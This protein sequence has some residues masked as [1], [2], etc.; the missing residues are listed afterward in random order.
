M[1]PKQ[2]QNPEGAA[3]NPAD[4]APNPAGAAPFANAAVNAAAAGNAPAN[5][6]PPAVAP[7]A[8]PCANNFFMIPPHLY[9]AHATPNHVCLCGHP[10]NAHANVAAAALAPAD[11]GPGQAVIDPQGLTGPSLLD[12]MPFCRPAGVPSPLISQDNPQ[13]STLALA[14]HYKASYAGGSPFLRGLWI[15]I[16][17]KSV[18]PLPLIFDRTVEMVPPRVGMTPDRVQLATVSFRF[19]AIP[20]GRTEYEVARWHHERGISL[21][22]H[23]GAKITGQAKR[24]EGSWRDIMVPQKEPMTAAEDVVARIVSVAMGLGTEVPISVILPSSPL[25]PGWHSCYWSGLL[26]ENRVD[27]FETGV[28]MI[29]LYLANRGRLG[30]RYM[31]R[32]AWEQRYGNGGGGTGGGRGGASQIAAAILQGLGQAGGGAAAAAGGAPIPPVAGPAAAAAGACWTCNQVGHIAANCPQGGGNR[33][34]RGRF[35]RRGGRGGGR[36]RGGGHY[37]GHGNGGHGGGGGYGPHGNGSVIPSVIPCVPVITLPACVPP[38]IACVHLPIA[39]EEDPVDDDDT[40]S[41]TLTDIMQDECDSRGE[42]RAEHLAGR[43]PVAPGPVFSGSGGESRL[44]HPAARGSGEPRPDDGG[45][46]GESN[47]EH[48]AV[49]GATAPGADTRPRPQPPRGSAVPDEDWSWVPLPRAETIAAGIGRM[50]QLPPINIGEALDRI[51]RHPRSTPAVLAAVGEARPYLDVEGKIHVRPLSNGCYLRLEAR[52]MTDLS[53]QGAIADL[54]SSRAARLV[55]DEQGRWYHRL[56]TVPK[57]DGGLRTISDLRS[58]NAVFPVP[59][60]FSHPS[61]LS[62]IL[63]GSRTSYAT[64]VDFRSAFYQ[65]RVSEDLARKF[66]FVFSASG[67]ERLAEYTSLPMGFSWSPYLFDLILKPLDILLRSLGLRFTRYV[68]DIA[69]LADSPERLSEDLTIL[70]ETCTEVGWKLNLS[71]TYLVAATVFVFLGVRISLRDSAASWSS[72]KRV[73]IGQACRQLLDAGT[74]TSEALRS[75]TGRLSW[76]LGVSPLFRVFL[77]P[78]IDADDAA[79]PR[80]LDPALRAAASFWL[81]SEGHQISTRWWP[82]LGNSAHWSADT[83]ASAVGVGWAGVTSPDGQ[84]WGDGALPLPPSLAEASSAA[85]EASGVTALLRFLGDTRRAGPPVVS[86]DHLHLRLDAKVVVGA[87]ERG[88]ARAPELVREMQAMALAVLALPPIRVTI[89]WIPREENAKADA[90][91]RDI[92]LADCRLTEAAWNYLITMAGFEPQVDLFATASNARCTRFYSRAPDSAAEGIDGM[93]AP[94]LGRAYAYPPFGLARAFAPSLA[95]YRDLSLPIVAVLPRDIAYSV[96]PWWPACDV[97]VFPPS[98]PVLLPAPYSTRQA[99]IPSP[100][101][102]VAL[103]NRPP[104]VT[105]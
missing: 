93:T 94:E 3:P 9:G 92:S 48:P 37:G 105:R 95:R 52:K 6:L 60:T 88:S 40:V 49:R 41:V 66:S 2:A 87:M 85:R 63:Q 69:L 54:L 19:V 104:S 16:H 102:L 46:G 72:K 89:E 75:L 71:K 45:S 44:E 18:G 26:T 43:G 1:P 34:G 53:A 29:V 97:Y 81:S 38:P 76:L 7:A 73:K 82:L 14:L 80:K 47:H 61:I 33:G 79:V 98:A 39:I 62:L 10:V 31:L 51:V 103:F 17:D 24:G 15:S 23:L 20:V 83:D 42:S 96:L 56:F 22:T 90:Q 8:N 4:A 77:R 30:G 35:G 58:V 13:T 101:P 55:M 74:Y 32:A 36:G 28:F 11:G 5:G 86:G 91:S 84:R 25:S 70:V 59:P 65:P 100:R 67:T 12:V 57:S 99:P 21:C 78:F 27:R 50:E 64:K 68:D